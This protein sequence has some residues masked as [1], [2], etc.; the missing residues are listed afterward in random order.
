MKKTIISFLFIVPLIAFS[1]TDST[2]TKPAPRPSPFTKPF[3]FGIKAG[4][5]FSNVSGASSI[6]AS[7]RTGF[8]AG[9]LVNM[10]GKIIGF[11]LEVLYSHQGYGYTTD[12]SSGSNTNNYISLSELLAINITKYVQ[13]QFGG[14]TGYLL[15]AKSSNDQSTGNATADQILKYSN[16]FDYGYGGGIEIHPIAG[17]LIGARYNISLSN[18]YKSAFSGY[19]GG[20]GSPSVD[21]KNN[22]VQLSVGFVF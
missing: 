9:I 17:L 6:S 18:L 15:N 8:H 3:Y 19:S 14:Q 13:L 11:R 4:P 12:S 1:Q 5:N 22:V 21:F 16:R 2:K 10:G 7:N 20:T